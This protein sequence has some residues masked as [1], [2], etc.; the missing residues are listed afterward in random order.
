MVVVAVVAAGDMG[1]EEAMIMDMGV[2]EVEETVGKLSL[3]F[4]VGDR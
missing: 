4:L 1:G 3:T 2:E